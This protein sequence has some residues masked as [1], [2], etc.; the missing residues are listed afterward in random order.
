MVRVLFIVTGLLLPVAAQQT[1]LP[2]RSTIESGVRV[3]NLH[4][5]VRVQVV[6][7]PKVR[8]R[9]ATPS[10]PLR[11]G[12]ISISGTELVEIEVRPAGGGALDVEV[13]LPYRMAIAVETKDGAVELSGLL[14][15]ADVVTMTGAIRLAAPWDITRFHIE[16][17]RRPGRIVKPEDLRTDESLRGATWE[18]RDTLDKNKI[19][20]GSL[21]VIAEFPPSIVLYPHPVPAES[22]VKIPWH[23]AELVD[24]LLKPPPREQ[25][26]D[27]AVSGQDAPDD[28]IV[29]RSDVRMVNLTVSVTDGA[30]RPV[31]GLTAADFSVVEDGQPQSI[32]NLQPAE[33]PFNLA[34]LLDMSGST[35]SRRDDMIEA[36]R[37]FAGIARDNDRVALYVLAHSLFWE[38]SPLTAS[39]EALLAELDRLPELS[40]LSPI[41]DTI[42]SAYAHELHGRRGE[43]NALI[44]LTDGL[45]NRL[46]GDEFL[47]PP[48]VPV[49]AGLPSQV[50]PLVFKR[51]A[52]AMGSLLYPVLLQEAYVPRGPMARTMAASNTLFKELASRTGGRVFTAQSL[53]RLYPVYGQVAEELRSVYSVGY[54]PANQEF[55]GS[56][57]AVRVQV[58][59]RG[60]TV[61][62]RSGYHAQ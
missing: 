18:L 38:V 24:S 29:F 54:Y 62:T 37:R 9:S 46:S 33:E 41:Y 32:A 20:Y 23:A 2:A 21:A 26:R 22:P 28:A 16:T 44:V 35:L 17:R 48:G 13:D 40:G 14:A 39:R 4:G 5:A 6:R 3:R 34:I 56:W 61:R 8:L 30:G 60:V 1:R 7:E 51:V 43:R 27:T 57:R 12:E 45:D 36:A 52:A 50:S 47:A 49:R 58:K 53:S 10:R 42:V 15:R 59:R 55:D 25:N 19:A 31:S 11:E